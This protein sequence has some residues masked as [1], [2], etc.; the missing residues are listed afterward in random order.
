MFS[1]LIDTDATL[2]KVFRH[3]KPV[4]QIV[5]F[6]GHLNIKTG[7]IGKFTCLRKS[8]SNFPLTKRLFN[9]SDVRLMM[10]LGI[11]QPLISIPT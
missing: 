11:D 7:P 9:S 5:L 8:V 3:L 6:R 1:K 10:S 4:T 2:S